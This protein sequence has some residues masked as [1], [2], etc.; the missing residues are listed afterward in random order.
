ML[1]AGSFD[2]RVII[3]KRALSGAMLGTY[4]I[5]GNRYGNFR[6][7][8]ETDVNVGNFAYTAKGGVL[9]LREDSLTRAVDPSYQ[10]RIDD[11]LYEVRGSSFFDGRRDMIRVDVASAPGESA[12][13]A[14]VNRKGETITVRRRT[15]GGIVD[16]LARARIDGYTPD[17]LVAGINQGDRKV[18]ILAADLTAAGWP[19]PLKRNDQLFVRGRLLNVE[20]VDDNTHRHGGDLAAYQVRA[21]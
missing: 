11:E 7:L 20:D 4:A 21:T 18:L 15:P 19:V 12:Y 16:A 8:S 13:A 3:L 6:Q 9:V 14:Y 2:R 10:I 5:E 1:P 17:E